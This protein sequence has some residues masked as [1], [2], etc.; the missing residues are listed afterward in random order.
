MKIIILKKTKGT[1]G[2]HAVHHETDEVMHETF[3]KTPKEALLQLANKMYP[4]KDLEE[5]KKGN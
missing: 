3:A 5:I 2:Y 1:G 4:P